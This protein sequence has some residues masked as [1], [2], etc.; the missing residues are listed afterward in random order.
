MEALMALCAGIGLAA[1]CGFRIF[2]PLFVASL[3][4]NI[5]IEIPMLGDQVLH[6]PIESATESRHLIPPEYIL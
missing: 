2:V 3:A 6:R 1:A 4:A 5:G